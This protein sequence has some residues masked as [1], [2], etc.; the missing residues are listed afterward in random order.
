VAHVY[1]GRCRERSCGRF[2]GLGERKFLI[3]F[4]GKDVPN[5]LNSDTRSVSASSMG[6]GNRKPVPALLALEENFGETWLHI[7]STPS[8]CHRRALT[9]ID[10]RLS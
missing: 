7:L 5:S 3:D 1:L 2:R 9:S 8:L 4:H 6:C 10:V